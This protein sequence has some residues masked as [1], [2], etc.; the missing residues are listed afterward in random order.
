[1][2][3][4]ILKNQLNKLNKPNK[5]NN[6]NLNHNLNLYLYLSKLRTNN[7]L[8]ILNKHKYKKVQINRLVELFSKLLKLN[9]NQKVD[10]LLFIITI[11][12]N[13]DQFLINMDI[14]LECIIQ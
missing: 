8:K 1:M 11:H 3:S 2:N 10:S 14:R 7:N 5:S 4:L 12:S 6:L 13:M 9:N